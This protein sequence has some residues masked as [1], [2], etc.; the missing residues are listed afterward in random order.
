MHAARVPLLGMALAMA[1]LLAENLGALAYREHATAE[2]EV[3]APAPELAAS[4]R[5]Q[6]I[7]ELKR[8]IAEREAYIS[9]L[10]L[11]AD[12]L[13]THHCDAE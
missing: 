6:R 11:R 13:R 10:K 12:A 1:L 3:S 7:E 8:E 9:Q 5:N 4:V 2:V